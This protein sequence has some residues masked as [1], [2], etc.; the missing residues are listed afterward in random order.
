MA[1]E[2]TPQPS[3]SGK[4]GGW[5]C[6]L[7]AALPFLWFLAALVAP[8]WAFWYPV[9]AGAEIWSRTLG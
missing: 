8:K 2:P 6:L 9:W 3:A 7:V 1:T 4:G 5:C